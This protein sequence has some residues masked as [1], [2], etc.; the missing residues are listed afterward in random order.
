MKT[1][2]KASWLFVISSCLLGTQLFA[3]DNNISGLPSKGVGIQGHLPLEKYMGKSEQVLEPAFSLGT[4]AVPPVNLNATGASKIPFTSSQVIPQEIDTRYPYSAI[5]KLWAVN[6]KGKAITCTGS[7]VQPG[8]VLTAGHCL[9]SGNGSNSGW[10][11]NFQ[12][13][14]AYRNGYAPFGVWKSVAFRNTPEAWYSGA[15]K[16]PHPTD[17]GI[18]V[19]NKNSSGKR[20]GDFSGWLGVQW[21]PS[22][23]NN[24]VTALGYS[25]NLDKGN[26][27]HRVDSM[28]HKAANNTGVYGSSMANG[29]DGG[30]IFINFGI[31]AAG[32]PFGWSG[33]NG[34]NLIVSVIS[35]T[36]SASLMKQGGSELDG[37]FGTFMNDACS[38]YPW[39]CAK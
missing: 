33:A 11:Y 22:F 34:R 20:V 19:F 27:S 29:S 5:G 36:A 8:I 26:I 18:I 28:V 17:Y 37:R 25:N 32:D 23:I 35:Y 1:G 4:L 21:T 15:G 24:Y 10:S 3:S 16:L 9:H 14:P 7:V 2:Y 30:P 38:L 6:S 13:A 39:A 31:A 12:F